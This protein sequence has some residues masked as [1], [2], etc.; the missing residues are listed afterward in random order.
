[1]CLYRWLWT[2]VGR[3]GGSL[4]ILVGADMWSYPKRGLGWRVPGGDLA[5]V[6]CLF[7]QIWTSSPNR[8]LF[9]HRTLMFCAF[10]VGDVERM[11]ADAFSHPLI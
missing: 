2:G 11:M 10:Y 9:R 5:G 1:M 8:M 4:E 6:T 7:D 3:P